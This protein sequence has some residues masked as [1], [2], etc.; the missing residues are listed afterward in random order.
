[1]PQNLIILDFAKTQYVA[2]ERKKLVFHRN[3]LN[4]WTKRSYL[5]HIVGKGRNT[6]KRWLIRNYDAINPRPILRYVEKYSWRC[7]Q[8][9]HC[10][11]LGYFHFRLY[12]S[13]LFYSYKFCWFTSMRGKCNTLC[14]RDGTEYLNYIFYCSL[15]HRMIQQ[16]NRTECT[17]EIVTGIGNLNCTKEKR[18]DAFLEC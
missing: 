13:I 18:C 1:M 17:C 5:C 16:E 6:N 14:Q 3:S 9:L 12:D 2:T 4:C 11:L 7:I 8:L 15:V 10:F